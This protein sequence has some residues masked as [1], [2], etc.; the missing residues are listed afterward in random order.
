[1][2]EKLC[3]FLGH[4]D[5]P[6]TLLRAL[7]AAVER[8]VAAYG[9]HDFV[10]GQHGRFDRLAAQAVQAVRSDY[11]FIRLT[12]LRQYHPAE[13]PTPLPAIF[14]DSFYPPGME[15]VPRRYA[16]PRA[17]RYMIDHADSLIVYRRKIAGNTAKLLDYAQG[18]A[19]RGL[20][21]IE[22]V[23]GQ[24]GDYPEAL[25]CAPD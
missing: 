17:N 1:M 20:L 7:T 4:R 6:E 5:A 22:N 24:P 9:I 19:R 2:Q 23:A 13:R 25:F 15:R 14:D 8:Q 10:V 16:I 3:F 11:P 18:R 21:R 12:L